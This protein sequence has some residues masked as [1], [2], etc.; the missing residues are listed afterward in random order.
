LLAAR[1]CASQTRLK[2]RSGGKIGSEPNRFAA[3]QPDATQ[4]RNLIVQASAFGEH[5][6]TEVKYFESENGGGEKGLIEK[7]SRSTKSISLPVVR[8]QSSIALI[9]SG[10]E[11]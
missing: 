5:L 2:T 3:L 11:G 9:D 10:R 4:S 6:F 8:R 7:E 1:G